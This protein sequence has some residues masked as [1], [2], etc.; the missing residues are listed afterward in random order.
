MV[1]FCSSEDLKKLIFDIRGRAQTL[2]LQAKGGSMFPSIKSGDHVEASL[3]NENDALGKGDIIL[4]E[5]D[6]YLYAHRVIKIKR[7]FIVAKGDLS[8]GTDGCIRRENVIAKV[9]AVERHGRRIDLYSPFNRFI[10]HTFAMNYV[11]FQYAFFVAGKFVGVVFKLLACF[12]K[13][14]AFRWLLKKILRPDIV[15]VRAQEADREALRDLYCTTLSDMGQGMVA[16]EKE[17]IWLVA[18]WGEKLVGSIVISRH[19]NGNKFWLTHGLIIKPLVRGLG[20]AQKLLLR[21]ISEARNEGA[22]RI[23]LFVN[24]ANSAAADLYQKNGF[25]I[26]RDHPRDFNVE[27]AD[28]YLVYETPK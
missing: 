2:R 16:T 7:G 21:A 26:S 6:G 10:A 9:V 5:K 27:E 23:G 12:Q 15:I 25:V 14:M 1:I 28:R 18:K 4:F 11:I 8:F 17:G 13:F 20:I 22:E 24:K 19:G 3:L